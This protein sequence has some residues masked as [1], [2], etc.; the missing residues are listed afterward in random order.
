MTTQLQ[1]TGTTN[2]WPGTYQP[3]ASGSASA[4]SPGSR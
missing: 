2:Y 4:A 3:W 1:Q